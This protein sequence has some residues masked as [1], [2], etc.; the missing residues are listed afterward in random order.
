[1]NVAQFIQTLLERTRRDDDDLW[2]LDFVVDF[3]QATFFDWEGSGIELSSTYGDLFITKVYRA[4][5]KDMPCYYRFR[6]NF[7]PDFSYTLSLVRKSAGGASEVKAAEYLHGALQ[8][9]ALNS[10]MLIAAK[11][12]N[13]KVAAHIEKIKAEEAEDEA[14]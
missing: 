3:A 14:A 1:M 8:R 9:D 6:I 4:P 7:K 12:I 13:A 11:D 5:G 10:F 2:E